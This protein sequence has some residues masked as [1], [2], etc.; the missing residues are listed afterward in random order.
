VTG[1]RRA[2]L[3]YALALGL[4]GAGPPAHAAAVEAGKSHVVVLYHGSYGQ[5]SLVEVDQELRR[6][7]YERLG[8]E[9]RYDTDFL[10]QLEIREPGYRDA[11]ERFLL[12]KYGPRGPDVVVAVGEPTLEFVLERRERLFPA[13]AV[14]FTH[15]A[16]RELEAI[17][18]PP[19][20]TG[21]VSRWDFEL[22]VE[23][24]LRLRPETRRLIVVLGATAWERKL[25]E[26][27]RDELRPVA[28]RVGLDFWSGPPI[29]ELEKRLAALPADAAVLLVTFYQDEQGTDYIPAFVLAR[30]AA[31]SSA[32]IF[33]IA[34]PGLGRGYVGGRHIDYAALG[35][36]TADLVLERLAGRTPAE[37]GTRES[38]LGPPRFDA[39]ELRRW[40]IP[41]SRLPPGSRVELEPPT[42]W[43][44]SWKS[45]LAVSLA[46][47]Q[48]ILI[49][50]FVLHRRI[51][52]TSAAAARRTEQVRAAVMDSLH[53]RVAVLDRSGRIVS[54]NEAWREL[55][56]DGGE[57]DLLVG[58]SYLALC[59]R[60]AEERG[61]EAPR[62]VDSLESV[63]AGGR[64]RSRIEY[65]AQD[66][67]GPRWWQLTVAPLDHEG[68]GA[69]VIGEDVTAAKLADERLR[70]ALEGLS[71]ATLMVDQN[72]VIV[73]VNAACEQLFGHPRAELLGQKVETL[74]PDRF[75]DG[76]RSL[77]GA[78]SASPSGRRMG[79]GRE[80]RARRKDGSEVAV[81]VGL[82]PIRSTSG[83][84]TLCSVADVSERVRLERELQQYRAETAHYGRVAAAGELSAAI[85][86]ELN[87]PLT[88]ILTN[89]Q[90]GRR[91]LDAESP[92]LVEL[93]E[94]LEDIAADGRRAGEVI[95]RLR[96]LLR[97][98]QP[99]LK[100]LDV[101][102]LVQQ[103][104]R[105]TGSDLLL[106]GAALDVE[107]APRLPP[108]AGDRVQL[109]QV[110]LN[111][112]L[113]ALDAMAG[114]P[115]ERRRVRVRSLPAAGREIRLEVRDS[116]IG[117][118]PEALPRLFEPFFTTK[119]TGMGMGLSIVRS[120]VESHGG[121]IAAA[122]NPGGG[123]SFT[124]TLP[125]A[126]A[127][128]A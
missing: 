111:L 75:R 80:L 64:A 51:S 61:A 8:N 86:H 27:I 39:R 56:A 83:P 62:I 107:L 106:R 25:L 115:P 10:G 74:V 42:P 101:N 76:H 122:N 126:A 117:I 102:E 45:L 9:L 49:A 63:L 20:V 67:R 119:E 121:R 65:L 29:A 128:A 78:F 73:L 72:G 124:V 22:V 50:G 16:R 123:A 99:E 14:V 3:G 77:R 19:D 26:S 125:A 24:F 1:G 98:S 58:G 30:V 95:H 82:Q 60:A 116:G 48:A 89:A 11:A 44:R 17:R 71:T 12:E 59:R 105:L 91:L 53:E 15:V 43:W 57:S 114:L 6:R 97:R 93:G 112:V 47:G 34:G 28:A 21:V 55:A 120:I 4:L 104:V 110:I 94:T 69:V 5:P 38:L 79:A 70:L 23:D 127:G 100:V 87:Q 46:V 13:C 52:R 103:V 36:D 37:I 108:V 68:G 35:R 66:P 92:D 7:L 31:A 54:V 96:S 113:N 88:G 2:A 40:G 32:P 33:G 90:A 84:M 109:T 85:A 18:L 41:R 81:E 118:P